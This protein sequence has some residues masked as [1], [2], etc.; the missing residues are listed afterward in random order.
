MKPHILLL[1]ANRLQKPGAPPPRFGIAEAFERQGVS[2]EVLDVNESPR[3]PFAGCVSLFASVD[4]WRAAKILFGR[5]K[6]YA[7]V[8]Y[9]QSG[10]LLILALRRIIGFKPLVA[11]VDVGDDS[12]WPLR[13]RIVAYCLKRADAVFSFA[14]DQTAYLARRYPGAKVQFLPQQIDTAFFT[15]A[16]DDGC[17]IL[18]VGND[19][20]RD[21]G[22]LLEAVRDLDVPLKLRTD[23]V[24]P[25]PGLTIAPRGDDEALRA[26]YRAAKIVVLP[27]H[28]MRHPGG[29]SSLFE[30]FACGKAVVA[31]DARGI[32]DYLQHEENCL[33]VPSGDAAAL[34]AAVLRLLQDEGLRLRLGKAA[35]R[36]AETELSQDRYAARL[37]NAFAALRPIPTTA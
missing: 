15:P 17:Y 27:L 22:T 1:P 31:S 28:D 23:C 13:A 12:N 9:Y 20:S 4:P 14:S 37:M 35:R 30:A 21:Y 32:R 33:V 10:A 36:Y 6:A 8:S 18:S 3:N 5:R 24:S 11:I 16:E 25:R 19:L 26:L 34:R 2:A 7:V 29:I